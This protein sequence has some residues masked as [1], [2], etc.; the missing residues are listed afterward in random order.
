[1]AVFRF[2]RFDVQHQQSTMKVGTDAMLVGALT[3]IN[4]EH[5]QVLDAGTGCGIIALMVAQ[6]SDATIDAVDLDERSAIE[7]GINFKN[8]PWH[9]RLY[10]FNDSLQQFSKNNPDKYDMIVSNPPFF[11][12]SLLPANSRLGMAKH[13]QMLNFKDF[14]QCTRRLLNNSGE[15]T[16]ILPMQESELFLHFAREEKFELKQICDIIPVDGKPANRRL[17]HLSKKSVEAARKSTITLRTA[18]GKFSDE[19]K[20]LTKDFHPDVYFV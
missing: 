15:L 12:N 19:Y 13:N 16:L 5:K 14:L 2:K 10:I 17:L 6:R 9:N 3:E 8:S 11:Q 4:P 1:M 18:S 20:H 7:A